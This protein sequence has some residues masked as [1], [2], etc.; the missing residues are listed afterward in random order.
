MQAAA[1]WEVRPWFEVRLAVADGF[2]LAVEPAQANLQMG[3]AEEVK[4]GAACGAGHGG[5]CW[6]VVPAAGHAGLK[7]VGLRKTGASRDSGHRHDFRA[8][9]PH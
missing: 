2:P 9:C 8:R 1:R 4:V 3:E 6:P 5:A 7:A